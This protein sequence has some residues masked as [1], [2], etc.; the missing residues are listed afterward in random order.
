MGADCL[1]C[2]VCVC[3]TVPFSKV[4]Q[5]RCPGITF[6][7]EMKILPVAG[8]LGSNE[9]SVCGLQVSHPVGFRGL[10]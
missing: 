2:T 6:S 7:V 5:W 3:V 1:I 9:M 4:R 10:T 8:V